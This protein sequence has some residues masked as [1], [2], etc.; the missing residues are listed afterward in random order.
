M[1]DHDDGSSTDIALM[2]RLAGGDDL[3]LNELMRRWQ[4]PLVS[5]IYRYVGNE[6][7]ALDLAQETFA[8]V[9]ESRRRYQPR[10]KFSTW[11]FSIAGN[12]CRNLARWRE[13]HP[14]VSLHAHASGDERALEETVRAPD[15][16][17][18]DTAERN[19]LAAAVREHLQALPHDL[20]T[21][22]L[23]FEYEDL[24]HREIGVVLGCSPKAVET[25]L[26]RARKILR[27][28]LSRWKIEGPPPT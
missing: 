22:V 26:Y 20:K 18:S 25:R 7:D 10:A 14:T 27:E 23:L 4:E 9:F 21:A 19:D 6:A 1:P 11:L 12:L 13:R 28:A 3:A 24:S 16:L 17:P 15:A 8:H 2:Q 5:F